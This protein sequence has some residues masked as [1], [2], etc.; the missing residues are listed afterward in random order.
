MLISITDFKQSS[1]HKCAPHQV[2]P[3]IL[4]QMLSTYSLYLLDILVCIQ[5]IIK[6]LKV[7]KV[8]GP[9]LELSLWIR[10]MA[11]ARILHQGSNFQFGMTDM[12]AHQSFHP[13]RRTQFWSF[14]GG[15][16]GNLGIWYNR[17]YLVNICFLPFK[18]P[19]LDTTQIT[20]GGGLFPTPLPRFGHQLFLFG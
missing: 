15:N 11:T 4:G 5:I 7:V 17:G 3:D 1:G 6:I 16:R 10:L 9:E 8:V 20:V 2:G 12:V 18:S 19:S 14:R 13:L